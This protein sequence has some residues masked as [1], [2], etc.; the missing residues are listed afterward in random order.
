MQRALAIGAPDQVSQQLVKILMHGAT[1]SPVIAAH[2][3]Q[4]MEAN[5][6]PILAVAGLA[7][8]AVA[9]CERIQAQVDR[10]L[11][12]FAAQEDVK[13]QHAEDTKLAEDAEG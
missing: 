4:A 3:R 5:A 12:L 11:S 9:R 1:A 8:E 6:D 10:L 7:M 2:I 13:D